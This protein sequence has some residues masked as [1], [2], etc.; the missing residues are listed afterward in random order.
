[1][2]TEPDNSPDRTISVFF[3]G[4]YMDPDV[5]KGRDVEPRAGQPATA[6]GYALRIGHK[7][8]LLRSPGAVACGMV[9][10]L[11]HA[12][13]DRLYWGAGLSEYRAEPM[14]VRTSD[15]EVV[16]A[17]CCNLLQPPAEHEENPDYARSLREAMLRAGLP[18]PFP[19]TSKPDD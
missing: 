18:G 5:L 2:H 11:T 4:L 16:S 13:L 8:T 7:A 15:G 19:E 1:M 6:E 10:S 12:E 9:Y 17:L 3:Y 14:T